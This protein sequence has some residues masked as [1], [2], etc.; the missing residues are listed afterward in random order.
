MKKRKSLMK[1]L[2]MAMAMTMMLAMSG[3]TAFATENKTEDQS[4]TEATCT[5]K[6]AEECT[7]ENC[8]IHKSGAAG[9]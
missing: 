6:S 2:T 9:K 8:S 7:T 4:G 5:A 3:I 1:V